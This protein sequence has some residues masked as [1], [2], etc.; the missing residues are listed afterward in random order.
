[1]DIIIAKLNGQETKLSSLGL[2]ILDFE[3]SPVTISRINKSFSGR[4]GYLDYGGNHTVKKLKIT[5]FY[6]VASK[7]DDEVFQTKINGL[8]SQVEPIWIA[9]DNSQLNFKRF[10]VFRSDTNSPTFVG[11]NGKKFISKW[12][13]EFETV[14]LPY[15]M[16]K[17]RSATIANNTTI[18]YGGTVACSQLEQPFYFVV[19]AKAASA[20]GFQLKVDN[21]VVDI[22]TPVVIGDVYQLTG[23]NFTRNGQNINKETNAGYF[24]IKPDAANKV[25]CSIAADIQIKNLCD[26][27]V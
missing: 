13:F 16:S 3:E 6:G 24:V 15:G 14:E 22:T 26:L 12:E 18:A 8:L 4:N 10:K 19:T 7:E 20:N 5:G 23:M 9:T 25:T 17:P 2:Q 11:S 27:Y 1:M 21:Q